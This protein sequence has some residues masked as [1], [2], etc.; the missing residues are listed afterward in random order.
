M[1]FIKRTIAPTKGNEFYATLNPFYGGKYSMFDK[2]TKYQGN[3]T[4][5]AWGRFSEIIG[6]KCQL[7]TS[8]A[9]TWYD[10]TKYSKGKTPKLG[11]IIEY[12]HKT[13]TGG[14]VG[15]VEEIKSNG[16][17]VLSMS[18]YNTFLF[19]LRTVSKKDNYCY[20]DYK[21]VGFIYPPKEFETEKHYEGEYPKLP[22]RGY[23]KSG[24]KGTEVKKLQK[25]LNWCNG[26]KLTCDGIFGKS[27]NT[28]VGKFQT[29]NKLTVDYK[30]GKKCIA[31]AK[32][33]TK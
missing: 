17:L 23:F 5:Y 1:K 7:P 14:H 30:F 32:E 27:T 12:K 21:L 33:I 19:K 18:G 15:I 26:T 28:Q 13:K 4:H 2:H 3:C 8:N 22:L 9:G 29:N 11:A 24:D 31:K 20:S 25:L 6:T 10:K 16:D